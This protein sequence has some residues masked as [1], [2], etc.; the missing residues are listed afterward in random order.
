MDTGEQRLTGDAA[1]ASSPS[2]G[3]RLRR[4]AAGHW[5]IITLL[6][7][8]AALRVLAWVAYQPALLYLD[9]FRYLDNVGVHSPASLH[10]IGYDLFVLAPTLTVGGLAL[11]AALQHLAVLAAALALYLLALRHGAPRWLAAIAA[12]PLLL[13]A[14]QVQIEQMIMSDSWQ[15]VLLVALLWVLLGR[16]APSPRRAAA[17]GL[18]LGVAVLFRL[19]AVSLAV[20]AVCYLLIAGG[21][22][23]AWGRW[24]GWRPVAA[25]C[26]A[27]LAAFAVVV[28]GYAGYYWAWT[29]DV[30]LSP[31]SASVLYGRAATVADCGRLDLDALQRLACPDEPLGQRKGVEGYAHLGGVEEWR[32]R[33][34]PGTG[35]GAVQRSFGW[36]VV[37]AQPFDV[38]R[39]VAA[40]FLKGF[41]AVRTDSP[42]DATVKR[43]HFQPW[44][45]YYNHR[46][47]SI[48]VALELSG[49]PPSVVPG[50]ASMLREYQLGGGYTPGTLL[51]AFGIVAL[52]ASSGAGRARSSGV[53]SAT[54]LAAGMAVTLLL[55]SAAF[56]FSW[57][58]QLPALVLLPFAGVLGITALCGR[59]RS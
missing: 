23:R 46:E 18:L 34:P 48:R 44:Y 56:E 28:G 55:A 27:F 50:L 20:P 31:T 22:W 9:S 26:L 3:R 35:I 25:R 14:Y 57:R 12:A 40:D 8:G 38:A 36:A 21:A 11:V 7:L 41:R 16:G 51:G 42:G 15:Q 45:Q 33:F 37:R 59:A 39:A 13:D 10:P 6:T 29:G 53:R 43:W 52:V 30:G 58:Y 2:P 5:L 17:G 4:L 47:R 49:R 54:L 19:V 32:A 1:V 24:R